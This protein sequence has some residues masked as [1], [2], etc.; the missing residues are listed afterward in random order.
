[1][2][3][4]NVKNG[5][6]ARTTAAPNHSYPSDFRFRDNG[7]TTYYKY[8]DDGGYWVDGKVE[9]TRVLSG[10]STVIASYNNATEGLTERDMSMLGSYIQ[11]MHNSSSRI[12]VH[13]SVITAAGAWRLVSDYAGKGEDKYTLTG[14]DE[15]NSVA[16]ALVRVGRRTLNHVYA[17][18][19]ARA[20]FSGNWW[21]YYM[22][23][24]GTSLYVYRYIN[25]VSTQLGSVGSGNWRDSVSV[26][27]YAG[28]NLT[29]NN[30]SQTLTVT[31]AT[32]SSGDWLP[33]A[34][35]KWL[36]PFAP[37]SEYYDG[38]VTAT[39]V[40]WSVDCVLSARSAG[41][42]YYQAYIDTYD[43]WAQLRRVSGGTTVIASG[44]YNGQSTQYLDCSTTTITATSI[45]SVTDAVVAQNGTWGASY[46]SYRNVVALLAAAVVSFVK[47]HR[48]MIVPIGV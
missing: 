28:G 21:G 9:I 32:F 29:Y 38:R 6:C 20:T 33:T 5:S 30:G 43:G 47:A 40:S 19:W 4:A 3:L 44:S 23:G 46:F 22:L 35:S 2:A 31:D 34:Q 42:K 10:V 16:N 14:W 27:G 12:S 48:M 25:G 26:E 8:R 41:G 7:S 45:G 11:V 1:M 24:G 37:N 15:G 18:M 36:E 39:G 13:D 17:Q